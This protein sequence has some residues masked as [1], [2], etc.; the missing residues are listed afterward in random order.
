MA[1][2]ILFIL[3]VLSL[4]T[5]AAV[6]TLIQNMSGSFLV[7]AQSSSKANYITV[8]N[9]DPGI[10]GNTLIMFV[11]HESFGITSTVTDATGGNTWTK[12]CTVSDSGNH[13]D[14]DVWV[15]FN[16]V[17]GT[18]RVTATFSSQADDVAPRLL[19]FNNV[20]AV[21]GCGG[22][23]G[24]G[25]T[26]TSGSITPT[27]TGDLVLQ[28]VFRSGTILATSYTPGSQTNITWQLADAD[29]RESGSTQWGVYNS[30]TG[31]N[32]SMSMAGS[33]SW[34][35]SSLFLKSGTSGGTPAAGIRVRSTQHNNIFPTAEGGPS[36]TFNLQF[37]SSGNLLVATFSSGGNSITSITDSN[38]N[39]W[40]SAGLTPH[41][42]TLCQI[43][44]AAGA[45]SSNN[46]VVTV[47]KDAYN[48]A[49]TIVF[50]D[51]SG[52]TASP[53]DNAVQAT[54]NQASTGNFN[55]NSITP[56]TTGGL[57]IAIMGVALNTISDTTTANALFD[58]QFY[59]NNT[60]TFSQLDENNGWAHYYN[61]TTSTV[62]FGWHP[63]H[64]AGSNIGNWA[65]L[66][67]AFKGVAVPTSSSR[68]SGGISISGG[69]KL[70]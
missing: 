8:S 54:G 65:A 41:N 55:T 6:P 60:G 59:D 26:V 34:I 36:G 57:I 10:A 20:T 21:D 67:V 62:T 69:A 2:G 52:A 51:V 44:Y 29:L 49:D 14:M 35:S 22:Q 5:W 66:S 19:E 38:S 32:T 27:V 18:R 56:T 13:L 23:T 9:P 11:L 39:T 7:A 31:L 70:Q 37:P 45:T 15:A 33:T 58:S 30:T 40:V 61:S 17:A 16:I 43:W 4:P 1:V 47:S 25:T 28:N 24:S 12:A 50:Y 48:T 64:P 53:F 68:V 42:D 3:L 63:L 46:L